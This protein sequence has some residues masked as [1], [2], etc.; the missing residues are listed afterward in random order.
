MN[1]DEIYIL[2]VACYLHDI[3]MGISEK[4]YEEFKDRLGGEYYFA[5]HP[6]AT[7]A[8]FVRAYH[9]EFSGLYIEKYADLY[10]IPSPEHA[11]AIKQVARGHRKTDLFDEKE[12]P[13]DYRLPNGNTV[14]LPYLAALI[15]ITDEI[16]VVASRNP[17]ILYDISI[18]TNEESIEYNKRLFAVKSMKMTEDT[19]LL[20]AE[21]K[22]EAII[23]DLEDMVASMQEKLDYC[24]QVVEKRTP[25][26]LTQKKILL[27]VIRR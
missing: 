23:K 21:E 13:S 20:L 1:A 16:D 26:K 19:F 24:R 15:R 5:D 14:C 22:D 8:D 10:D 7:K 4:D 27:N 12:Y 11:Y 9:N 25:F 17:L 2:L 6:D 18:L 3:G